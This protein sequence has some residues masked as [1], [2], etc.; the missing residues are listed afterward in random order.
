MTRCS[1]TSTLAA[2]LVHRDEALLTALR[3]RHLAPLAALS[4]STRDRLSATLRSWLMNMGNRTAIADERQVHPQTV[5]YRLGRL[6]E[7]FG[8]TLDD[9]AIRAALLLAPAWVQPPPRTT[10]EPRLD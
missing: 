9:P 1:L 5:R 6:R 10:P 4:G 2:L 3:H 7:L 8:S